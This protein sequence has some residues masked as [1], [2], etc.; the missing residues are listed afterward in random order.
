[1]DGLRVLHLKWSYKASLPLKE[2]N[3]EP[4]AES[5]EEKSV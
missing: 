4:T 5:A 3:E 2:T 1:M